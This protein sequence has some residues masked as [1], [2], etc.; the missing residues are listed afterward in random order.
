MTHSRPN[1][2]VPAALVIL[3]LVP[4][5]AGLARLNDL[6]TG[7]PTPDTA[8]FHASPLPVAIHVATSIWFALAGV[9]QFSPTL[10]RSRWHRWSGRIVVPMGLAAALS[11]IW[12]TLTYAW[13]N[14]DGEAVYAARLIFGTAMTLS[15]ILG[16]ATILNRNIPAHRA[17]ML[18][19]YAIG[20]GAGTQ[21]FTHLPWYLLVGQPGE[22]PRAVMMIGGWVINLAVAEILIAK[23]KRRANPARRKL[24]TVP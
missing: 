14:A 10:R 23:D 3:T 5:I 13:A 16:V 7:A 4:V 24:L 8:R 18:R 12:M 1:W 22:A 6:A 15:L 9:L 19:A 2:R 21:V 11:G 17:W 20:M